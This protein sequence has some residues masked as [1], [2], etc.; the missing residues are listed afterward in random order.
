MTAGTA[1]TPRDRGAGLAAAG[2]EGNAKDAGSDTR[3]TSVHRGMATAAINATAAVIWAMSG[4]RA[5]IGSHR[6]QIMVSHVEPEENWVVSGSPA[7]RVIVHESR[8]N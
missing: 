8:P 2:W 7:T 3:V 6:G 4:N 5:G 1:T